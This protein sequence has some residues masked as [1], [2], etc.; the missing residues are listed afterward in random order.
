METF[1]E[2]EVVVTVDRLIEALD[3]QPPFVGF[4][5]GKMGM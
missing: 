1:G 5:K 3:L 2:M 4:G